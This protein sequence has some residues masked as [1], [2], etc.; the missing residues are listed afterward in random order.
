MVDKRNFVRVANIRNVLKKIMYLKICF[1]KRETD[2]KLYVAYHLYR[3]H[4]MQN[5]GDVMSPQLFPH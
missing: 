3:S 1:N 2:R 4:C 5:Q